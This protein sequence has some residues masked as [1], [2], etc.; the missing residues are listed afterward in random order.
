MD[1]ETVQTITRE[2]R[3]HEFI[4]DGCGASLGVS[5]ENESGYYQRLGEYNQQVCINGAWYKM[6][7]NY[8]P[9]CAASKTADILSALTNLGFSIA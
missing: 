9:E 7:A 5:V 4:C 8:C 6:H 1:R 2:E 3:T